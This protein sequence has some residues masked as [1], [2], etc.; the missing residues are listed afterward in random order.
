M[1]I[2]SSR[3]GSHFLYPSP[4][5]NDDIGFHTS[6]NRKESEVRNTIIIFGGVTEKESDVWNTIIILGG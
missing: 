2:S 6:L 4:A 1:M 5:E 3:P